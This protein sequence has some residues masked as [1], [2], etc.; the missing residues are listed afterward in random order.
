MKSRYMQ[1]L[2]NKTDNPLEL[3]LAKTIVNKLTKQANIK[4]EDVKEVDE[5][6]I[7]E[8]FGT[9][10]D[11]EKIVKSNE[12]IKENKKITTDGLIIEPLMLSS[13]CYQLNLD[14]AGRIYWDLIFGTLD[15]TSEKIKD[16]KN[17]FIGLLHQRN[18]D[19]NAHILKNLLP[20]MAYIDVD[21]YHIVKQDINLLKR[22]NYK[23]DIEIL[24]NFIKLKSNTEI[25]QETRLELSKEIINFHIK[26]DSMIDSIFE[27]E[28]IP[29][30]KEPVISRKILEDLVLVKYFNYEE[31]SMIIDAVT[32][33]L[34]R[35]EMLK[36][37]KFELRNISINTIQLLEGFL[38][39]I[40]LGYYLEELMR[41]VVGIPN[42]KT[43]Y[44]SFKEKL[45]KIN[46]DRYQ[47]KEINKIINMCDDLY[48][49]N[50]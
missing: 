31:L 48:N 1:F 3:M 24:D 13:F 40:G 6:I 36:V 27:V 34:K 19:K 37:M 16:F 21:L 10:K 33:S 11:Y 5:G 32:T 20:Y 2:I 22:K 18:Y 39:S 41:G 17:E 9:N 30:Y 38:N 43:G 8:F 44:D 29:E 26:G 25:N 35:K 28:S 49:P 7:V 15:V 23:T 47:E 45:K 46:L 50:K 14:D 12:V 4:L 42:L